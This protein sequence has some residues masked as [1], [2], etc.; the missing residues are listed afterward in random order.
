MIPNYYPKYF[1]PFGLE[2]SCA[3]RMTESGAKPAGVVDAACAACALPPAS[4]AAAAAAA[5]AARS[6]PASAP[7]A[8]AEEQIAAAL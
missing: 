6:A 5:A 2:N 1:L 4:P 7:G 3:V 8:P